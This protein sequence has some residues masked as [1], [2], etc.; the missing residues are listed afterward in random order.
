MRAREAESAKAVATN[1]AIVAE[2]H[3]AIEI[4]EAKKRIQNREEFAKG[5]YKDL[6]EL[7]AAAR[8]L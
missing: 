1:R 7:L 5:E 2:A 6:A 8:K 3:V 4:R